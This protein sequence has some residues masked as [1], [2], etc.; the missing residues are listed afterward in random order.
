MSEYL[1][2]KNWSEYQHYKKRNPPWIKMHVRILNDRD[3]MSLSLA[4]KG[5]LMLLWILG[6][7]NNGKVPNDIKEMNF[8]LRDT[9]IKQKD[10]DVLIEQGFLIKCD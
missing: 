7:E 8:R 10:I 5:L 2:I 6:S 1:Q 3:F 9:N 4:S